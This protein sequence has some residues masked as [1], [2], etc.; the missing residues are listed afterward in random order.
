MANKNLFLPSARSCSSRTHDPRCTSFME[1]RIAS[2]GAPLLTSAGT[3]VEIPK[4]TG[5]QPSRSFC[6]RTVWLSCG[7]WICGGICETDV[8]V[9]DTGDTDWRWV[10]A[11]YSRQLHGTSMWRGSRG[12]G[13][14]TLT[15]S[16]LTPKVFHHL[17]THFP[18]VVIVCIEKNARI[19]T[20]ELHR[21]CRHGCLCACYS[22]GQVAIALDK[23]RMH[24]SRACEH[25]ADLSARQLTQEC[26]SS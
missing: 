9:S 16:L 25:V 14:L 17:N 13:I 20:D 11:M 15:L 5:Y 21:H 10:A 2:T 8:A 19:N 3:K 23:P 4:P 7:L 24:V 22:M 6:V 18:S 1:S 26:G 12:D